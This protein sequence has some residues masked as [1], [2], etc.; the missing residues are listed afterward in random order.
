MRALSLRW[1][2]MDPIV[3]SEPLLLEETIR[4]EKKLRISN[5]TPGVVDPRI[6]GAHRIDE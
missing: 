1:S 5:G 3:V 6:P 2:A 4:A